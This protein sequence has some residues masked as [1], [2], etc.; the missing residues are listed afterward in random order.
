MTRRYALLTRANNDPAFRALVLAHAAEDVVD[1]VRD[2]VWTYDPRV[3]PSIIPFDLFPRQ[4]EFLR[5]L[6]EGDAIDRK[7][8]V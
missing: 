7:S 3:T 6:G 4:V 1:W 2:W 5:W 8:V